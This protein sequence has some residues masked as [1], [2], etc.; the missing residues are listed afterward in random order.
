[1]SVG[2]VDGIACLDLDQAEDNRAS[3]DMNVVATATGELVEVQGTAEGAP[4]ARREHEALLDLA[5]AGCAE[6]ALLQRAALR[7]AIAAADAG[8]GRG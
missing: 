3:V 2:L 1:V 7:T 8:S 5:L 6:L 4:F